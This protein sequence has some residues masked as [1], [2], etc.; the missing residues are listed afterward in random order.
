M[1]S[2]CWAW[3]SPVFQQAQL[4]LCS[5][6]ASPAPQLDLGKKVS[7]PQDL[8]MEELSLR[9]NRG[10]RLFQQRQKRMQRFV[11]EHPSGY[12][13]VGL[14]LIPPSQR[15]SP[16]L[17]LAA[18]AGKWVWEVSAGWPGWAW[19]WVSIRFSIHERARVL[20]PLCTH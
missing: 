10:S 18:F 12:R 7:T 5:P 6:W 20:V 11:F 16:S 3:G 19:R 1:L 2:L 9:N 8:M 4:W 15:D 14:Q 17:V 13:Q